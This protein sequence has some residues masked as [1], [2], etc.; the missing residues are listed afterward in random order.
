[1]V[2]VSAV[3]E[4]AGIRET[5]VGDPHPHCQEGILHRASRLDR[6][7]GAAD[8]SVPESVDH[9]VADLGLLIRDRTEVRLFPVLGAEVDPGLEVVVSCIAGFL[10]RGLAGD[11]ERKQEISSEAVAGG[12]CKSFQG[13]S[14]G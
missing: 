3:S 6:D 5:Q 7:A 1:M 14:C 9:E 4:F 12:R 13:C 10:D 2:L 11:G 8:R